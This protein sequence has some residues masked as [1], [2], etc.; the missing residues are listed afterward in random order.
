M[1]AIL[2]LLYRSVLA[3]TGDQFFREGR[4]K[5][6]VA[7]FRFILRGHPQDITVRLNLVRALLRLDGNY[8]P[9][10][11]E[12]AQQAVQKAPKNAEAHGLYALALMRGGYV[13]RAQVEAERAL[14]YNPNSY[15]GLVARGRIAFWNGD[16]KGALAYFQ[17]AI[18]LYPDR[19]MAYAY[20]LTAVPNEESTSTLFKKYFTSYLRLHPM[21]HPHTELLQDMAQ[22]QSQ[23]KQ[24]PKNSRSWVGAAASQ[25]T[26]AEK[27]EGPP[28]SYDL[29]IEWVDQLIALPVTINGVALSMV[30]DTGAGDGVVL[31]H[32]AIERLGLKPIGQMVTRGVRGS[33]VCTTYRADT[34]QVGPEV[35][36]IVISCRFMKGRYLWMVL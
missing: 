29:P 18:E 19:D 34:V 8:W 13:E 33:E 35:L 15:Y 30:L 26:Y 21:G 9:Y 6:A 1:G 11:V 31:T 12:E 22:Y 4:F 7:A 32:S 17:R 20:W 3:E 27:G 23:E 24:P 36:Q 10:A 25:A 14:A 2:L 16:I 5:E 28:V